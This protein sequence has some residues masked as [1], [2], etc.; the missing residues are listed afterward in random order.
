MGVEEQLELLNIC[1]PTTEMRTCSYFDGI[2][3]LVIVEN[4]DCVIVQM[5]DVPC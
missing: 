4:H 2:F 3:S 5:C 1:C